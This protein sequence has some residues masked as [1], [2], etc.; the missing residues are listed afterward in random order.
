M[1]PY[2]TFPGSHSGIDASKGWRQV[3]VMVA[4]LLL[5]GGGFD[6]VRSDER[7][8]PAGV[9]G[10]IGTIN[11][12]TG[13]V[14]PP[15]P[16]QLQLLRTKLQRA[17]TAK[18]AP[19]ASVQLPNGATMAV[20]GPEALSFSVTRR[21]PDGAFY[22]TCVPNMQDAIRFWSTPRTQLRHVHQ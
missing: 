10:L 12:E 2:T 8:P 21:T 7:K 9:S 11:P 22:T 3:G 15:T 4:F 14:S 5:I 17:Y 1:S 20:P 6:L 19:R 18:I 16:E 13:Q